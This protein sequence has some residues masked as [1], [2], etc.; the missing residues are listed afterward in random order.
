MHLVCR[1]LVDASC[2]DFLKRWLEKRVKD[3][4]RGLA[5]ILRVCC[6]WM[7]EGLMSRDSSS[8]A[9]FIATFI[10][11]AMHSRRPVIGAM[12]LFTLSSMLF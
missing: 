9:Q 11:V 12:R 6:R 4:V 5:L 7:L 2:F 10:C 8:L 1:R 3:S